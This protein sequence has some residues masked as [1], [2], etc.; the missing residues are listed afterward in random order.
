MELVASEGCACVEGVDG[1][2]DGVLLVFAELGVD[3]QG[4]NLGGGSLGFGE[5]TGTVA[6]VGEGGLEV[7]GQGIVDFGTYAEPGEVGAELVAA[8]RADHVLMEDVQ[9]AGIGV[10]QDD[11]VGDGGGVFRAGKDADAGGEEEL[12]VAGG[13]RAAAGVAFR[14]VLELDLENGGLEGV[15][16]GVPA[17]L[18]VEV[19]A[20]HA[21]GA[22]GAGAG[23]EGRT[24][25]GDEAGIAECGQVLGGVEAEGGGGA[26]RSGRAEGAVG[27]GPGC[28]ESLGGVLDEDQT[29]KIVG[30]ALE[31]VPVRALAIEVDGQNGLKGWAGG[32][33]YEFADCVRREVEGEGVDVGEDGAGSGAENGAS[34]GEEAKRGGDDSAAGLGLAGGVADAGRGEGEPKGV[35]AAGAADG[36][37]HVAGQGGGGL[38]GL[39]LR[40]EDEAL[41]GADGLNG[42]H[43][44]ITQPVEL[45]CEVQHGHR[46]G[47]G[48]GKD[49]GHP[50]M[51]H[52]RGTADGN[53]PAES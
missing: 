51:V 4:E 34:R 10:G 30:E 25:G 15:E 12:V 39:D 52:R 24:R 20:A 47:R 46:L 21:V 17:D 23:V 16:A 9:G 19:A 45:P 36:V 7:E 31:C 5:V 33:A 41:R 44:F 11:T 28:A 18:V 42:G 37:R 40:P 22:E 3:W 1:G 35:R 2:D 26:E 38:K 43:E 48:L 29:G 49:R 53:W 27:R 50:C 8:W 6:E 32:S 14:Q 13:E